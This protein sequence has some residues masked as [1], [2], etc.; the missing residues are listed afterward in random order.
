MGVNLQLL[1]ILSNFAFV[2]VYSSGNI[3][4]FF[5]SEKIKVIYYN[6]RTDLTQ[7]LLV[8]WI[9]MLLVSNSF[10]LDV[11]NHQRILL[12][13]RIF[14]LNL[15]CLEMKK[16]LCFPLDKQMKKSTSVGMLPLNF[17]L[18]KSRKIGKKLNDEPLCSPSVH[19][20]SI[21]FWLKIYLDI[22]S[23]DT[24]IIT[25]TSQTFFHLILRVLLG[26]FS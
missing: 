18:S 4:P 13:G 14:L 21:G 22:K 10:K 17:L 11:N 19:K 8:N 20:L 26:A 5:F 2:K 24:I 9:L 23:N 3:F 15:L 1:I 12:D 16:K 6:V 25:I 7:G